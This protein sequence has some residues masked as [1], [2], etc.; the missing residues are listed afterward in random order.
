MEPDLLQVMESAK[1]LP[2]TVARLLPAPQKTGRLPVL[3]DLAEGR[4]D[5]LVNNA[6][7]ITLKGN[8]MRKQLKA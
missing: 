1:E 3:L 4:L 8:S 5:R 6:Y 7:T 2:L